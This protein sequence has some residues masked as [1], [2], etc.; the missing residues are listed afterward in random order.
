MALPLLKSVEDCADFSK[1]VEPFIPQLYRLPSQVLG[2]IGSIDGLKQLYIGTNPLITGFAASIAFGF[3]FL[4]ASE[5]NRNY[6]QVDRMWSILPNLY[7]V[8]LAVWARLAGL[9]HSRLDLIAA[10]TT[11][12]SIR[13]THNYWRKGGYGIGSEDY[14]WAILQKYV[15]KFAWFIFNV[16]FISFIQSILLFSFSCVPAYAILLSSQFDQDVT[17]GDKAFFALE[18][19]LVVSEWF[20]DDYQTAK[21]KYRDDGRVPEGFDKQDLDRGFITSGLFAYSR[22]PN[23]LAEQTIWFVLYQWSCYATNQLY[24]GWTGA[25]SWSLLLLFQG[26]TWLTELITARKY[27]EYREYQKQVGMFLPT[28]LTPYTSPGPS[29]GT[30]KKKE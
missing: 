3:G 30:Q 27:P 18:V 9:P 14:R 22:H 11:L 17:T 20:S 12:W 8:H 28:S 29:S 16:T 26:S 2:N 1:T 13:L 15:N 6:S 19:A 21:Y 5:V 4:V 7:V 24:N 10:A 23:F 25:G